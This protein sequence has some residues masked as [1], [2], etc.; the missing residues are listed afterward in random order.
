MRG[1]AIAR[2]LAIVGFAVAFVALD[3]AARDNFAVHMTQHMTLIVVLAPLIVLGWAPRRLPRWTS[4]VGFALL[5]V[6]AQTLALIAWHVPAVSD[7][8]AAHAPLHA[9]E[10][11]TLF[12][13][14]VAA[15]WVILA[16][17]AGTGVRF[18]A[19]A[20]TA[21]P[22]LLLGALLTF[23]P[24]PWYAGATLV[25]QQTGG[26]VMWGPA[27]L[28]YVVAAAWI[29]ASAIVADERFAARGPG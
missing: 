14:S 18:A 11:L 29:V 10:H 17:P 23:A 28:A 1:R 7:A 26:A 16:S 5:A 13:T 27:G 9:V 21:A 19:C 25:E 22:M 3:T 6:G 20:A 24:N 4:G 2:I 15:W 8:N 12:A